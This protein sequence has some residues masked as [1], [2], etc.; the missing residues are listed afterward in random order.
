MQNHLAL[1]Y[2]FTHIQDFFR[3]QI[4]ILNCVIEQNTIFCWTCNLNL[5]YL[6][7][8]VELRHTVKLFFYFYGECRYVKCR[9]AENHCASEHVENELKNGRRTENISPKIFES[10]SFSVVG[11]AK[12][13]LLNGIE[14]PIRF[15][16]SSRYLF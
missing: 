2:F 11:S 13:Y 12:E 8:T 15:N 14:G 4:Q 5:R 9:H 6:W 3:K 10:E 16:S 7:F 1:Y